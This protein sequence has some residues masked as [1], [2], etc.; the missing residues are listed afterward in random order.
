[1][2]TAKKYGAAALLLIDGPLTRGIDR[3]DPQ[4]PA[5]GFRMSKRNYYSDLLLPGLHISGEVLKQLLPETDFA[6]VQ[7]KIDSREG[8]V[9]LPPMTAMIEIVAASGKEGVPG[10]NVIAYRPSRENR[11]GSIEDE[12]RIIVIGAHHDHI[13]TSSPATGEDFIFN[14]ADDNASGVAAV[15]ELAERFSRFRGDTALLFV[16][17]SAEELGL[18]G[19][20]VLIND[21]PWIEEKTMLMINL[22]MIGRK[23]ENGVTVRITGNGSL[24]ERVESLLPEDFST[25]YDENNRYLSDSYSFSQKDIPTLSFFTGKHPQYHQ[26]D[27]EAELLDFQ[28]MKE[29]A[30]TAAVIISAAAEDPL[31]FEVRK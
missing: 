8:P 5:P 2:E 3:T 10:R 20:E 18:F 17:F 15:L 22:D 25:G 31:S 14:G 24:R 13:G 12:E 29:I 23:S 9:R 26:P 16:T 21:F 11:N 30:D 4:A 1:M 7:K 28:G 27:D 19:S 6:D